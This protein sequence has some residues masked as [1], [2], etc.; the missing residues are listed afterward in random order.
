MLCISSGNS[1]GLTT[2]QHWFESHWQIQDGAE[3]CQL[4][5]I[6]VG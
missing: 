3:N 1:K 4:S 5:Q 2:K 6:T